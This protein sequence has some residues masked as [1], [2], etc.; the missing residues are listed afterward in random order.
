MSNTSKIALLERLLER[1]QQ[2]DASEDEDYA[3]YEM[4]ESALLEVASLLPPDIALLAAQIVGTIDRA[5]MR[6]LNEN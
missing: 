4:A 1:A 3:A 2:F 6:K 5:Y